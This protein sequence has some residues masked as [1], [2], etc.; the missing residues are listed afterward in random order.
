MTTVSREPHHRGAPL[1]HDVLF[2]SLCGTQRRQRD[3]KGW[4][5]SLAEMVGTGQ[6]HDECLMV[7]E[8]NPAENGCSGRALGHIVN[9]P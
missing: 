4:E 2:K 9:V 6:C 7:T 8:T 1:L 5:P 3:K